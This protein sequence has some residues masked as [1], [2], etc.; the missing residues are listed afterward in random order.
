MNEIQI[1]LANWINAGARLLYSVDCTAKD[2]PDGN[3]Y[4]AGYALINK[5]E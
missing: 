5:Q 3:D 4:E 2:V 1:L